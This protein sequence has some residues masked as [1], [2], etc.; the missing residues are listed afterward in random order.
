MKLRT[1]LTVS[2]FALTLPVAASADPVVCTP[3]ASIVCNGV[4]QQNA[5]ELFRITVGLNGNSFKVTT[6]GTLTID[7]QLFLFDS[8]WNG[9]KANDDDGPAGTLG[10]S[11]ISWALGSYATPKVYYVALSEYD[12]DPYS[13]GNPIFGPVQSPGLANA[14]PG[15][16][17][18]NPSNPHWAGNDYTTGGAYKL[19]FSG[20]DSAERFDASLPEPGTLTLLGTGLA[21]LLAQR[22]RRRNAVQ[23]A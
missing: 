3:G 17:P 15:A 5:P 2:A 13:G 20:V 4:L 9:L 6:L 19:T 10:D 11:T 12:L 21:G 22:R 8:D 18:F 14:L 1:L 7:T 16:A 23:T